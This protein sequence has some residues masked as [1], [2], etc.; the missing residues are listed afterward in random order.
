MHFQ[1]MV[2]VRFNGAYVDQ[3]LR[4]ESDVHPY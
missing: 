4:H 3:M 2:G 1:V